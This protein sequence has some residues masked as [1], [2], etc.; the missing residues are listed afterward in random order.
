MAGIKL[1]F[2]VFV[3]VEE[4][5]STLISELTSLPI[6]YLTFSLILLFYCLHWLRRHESHSLVSLSLPPIP[7]P[8]HA[9]YDNRKRYPGSQSSA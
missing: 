9:K 4:F 2:R 8:N 5:W 6:Y 1:A 7:Q 3:E